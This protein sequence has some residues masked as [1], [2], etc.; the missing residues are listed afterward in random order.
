[1]QEQINFKN[2]NQIVNAIKEAE[3]IANKDEI[4]KNEIFPN[5]VYLYAGNNGHTNIIFCDQDGNI[6]LIK[7]NKTEELSKK[8]LGNSSI[9][10]TMA[11]TNFKDIL[12]K[13]KINIEHSEKLKQY[14][15]A[16]EKKF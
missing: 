9:D 13:E 7:W 5:T 4:D 3:I 15:D 2:Q 1:M 11:Y 10:D 16:N 12:N 14:L 8:N 6:R